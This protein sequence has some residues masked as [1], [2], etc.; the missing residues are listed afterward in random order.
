[1]LERS[2]ESLCYAVLQATNGYTVW[3]HEP[4]GIVK[5]PQGVYTVSAAWLKKGQAEA[6]RVGS[7]PLVVKATTAANLVLGGP[8]TNWV[9]LD[10]AGRKLSMSYQLKGADGGLYRLAQ[11]DRNR[12]PEFTVY[13]GGKKALSGKF[14]FG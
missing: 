8:L 5:V 14:E 7:E 1:E 2:G 4:P 9:A 13:H 11:E 10:R 3:L 6:S 12:P